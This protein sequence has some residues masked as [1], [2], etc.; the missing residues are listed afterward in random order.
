[1]GISLARKWALLPERWK[2]IA[3][4]LVKK[5]GLLPALAVN[6]TYDTFMFFRERG[7]I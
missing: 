3:Q 6:I 2:R 7:A 5:E 1:M 4:D